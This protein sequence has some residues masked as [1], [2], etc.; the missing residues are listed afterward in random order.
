MDQWQRTWAEPFC[1]PGFAASFPGHC[2]CPLVCSPAMSQPIAPSSKVC[3][4]IQVRGR[5]HGGRISSY[6]RVPNLSP[7]L[8][9]LPVPW[10]PSV[11]SGSTFHLSFSPQQSSLKELTAPTVW[12]SLYL[13]ILLPIPDTSLSGLFCL[14]CSCFL[15][16]KL[17]S[18]LWGVS[19]VSSC[20]EALEIVDDSLLIAPPLAFVTILH[21]VF[22]LIA[23]GG[24]E[25]AALRSPLRKDSLTK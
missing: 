2:A 23:C 20:W 19:D 22:L 10:L 15:V 12:T 8:C 13:Y 7:F 5:D 18:L 17:I 14:H 25:D 3:R 4:W 11:P 24:H 1:W 16:V 21:G 6:L 9:P